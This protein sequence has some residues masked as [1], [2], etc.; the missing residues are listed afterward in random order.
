[1]DT[2]TYSPPKDARE[3]QVLGKLS[4]IRDMLQ[5]L[6]RDR[7]N[8]IRSQ[9]VIPLYDETIEQVR[10]LSDV[11]TGDQEENQGEGRPRRRPRHATFFC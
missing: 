4:A 1:M 11:R 5:L 8:Y 7:S 10:Q 3:E 9:D 2:P 6:R